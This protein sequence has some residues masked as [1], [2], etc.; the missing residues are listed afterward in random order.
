MKAKRQSAE[1]VQKPAWRRVAELTLWLIGIVLVYVA[2]GLLPELIQKQTLRDGFRAIS[3]LE[4]G[5]G[6]IVFVVG[7]LASLI[8]LFKSGAQ[9]QTIVHDAKFGLRQFVLVAVCAVLLLI[10][11]YPRHVSAF[12]H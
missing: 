6:I 5:W 3:R 10:F 9:R 11:L 7:T 12:F 8:I 1:A 4:P 2:A